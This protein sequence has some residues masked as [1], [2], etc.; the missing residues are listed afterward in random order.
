LRAGKQ[1]NQKSGARS[2]SP[3]PAF[4]C[5]YPLILIKF[6]LFYNTLFKENFSVVEKFSYINGVSTR[7]EI[8]SPPEEQIGI[9]HQGFFMSA[10]SEKSQEV[11][12]ILRL[13][14]IPLPH[15]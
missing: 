1:L 11:G 3:C 12:D 13:V 9:R 8:C 5:S 7:L 10:A 4:Y 15:F 14:I 2:L 6:L